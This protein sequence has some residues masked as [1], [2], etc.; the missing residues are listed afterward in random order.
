M[1]EIGARIEQW[2]GCEGSPANLS[3]AALLVSSR[4]G[5][6][7]SGWLTSNLL[8]AQFQDLRLQTVRAG[9]PFLTRTVFSCEVN[10]EI[11]LD[12]S[13]PSPHVARRQHSKLRFIFFSSSEAVY[14]KVGARPRFPVICLSVQCRYH[15]RAG[16]APSSCAFRFPLS[17]LTSLT[18]L[19]CLGDD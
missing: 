5:G 6:F 15:S 1:R 7:G 4:R 11:L 14:G 16:E 13:S 18:I 17:I 8:L 19:G 9:L 2:V 12:R 10:A 3:D